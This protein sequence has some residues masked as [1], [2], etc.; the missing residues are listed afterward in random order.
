MTKPA[1]Q[2]GDDVRPIVVAG[3]CTAESWELLDAVA[4]P[5]VALSK[6]LGFDYVFKASFDKANRTSLKSPRGPG[7]DQA[8]S[9]FAKL[10]EKHGVGLLTDVHETIQVEAA[11]AVCD[12]LQIPA[13]L[14]RQTDLVAKAA[15]SGRIVNIKKG[16]FLA[17]GA[18]ANI[19]D[20]AAQAAQAAGH[21][22]PRIWLTERGTTFGYGNLVVD[23]RSLPIMAKTSAPVILDITHSTQLPAAGGEGGGTSGAQ[24]CYAP[25]LARAAAASGY[26]DGFFL[27]VHTNPAEAVSD[28]EAQLTVAQAT[29]LLRQ[30]IPLAR[31]GKRLAREIDATFVD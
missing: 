17:P 21:A 15:A 14:C 13:F 25:T 19:F 5:M 7:M 3:P 4:A 27:E 8:M 9:W 22:S 6:E 28:A 29:A 11:A 2:G 18:M 20:K 1:R 12:V 30:V 24:R 16:Q 31:E 10:K 26:V 23:M